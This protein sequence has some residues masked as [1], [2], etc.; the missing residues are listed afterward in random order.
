MKRFLFALLIAASPFWARAGAP[1]PVDWSPGLE[2]VVVTPHKPGPLMW[3]VSKG[4]ASVYLIGLVDPVPKDLAWDSSAVADALKGARFLLLNAQASVGLVE[5]L[6]FMTWHSDSVYLPDDTPMESTL[7][8]ALRARFVFVRDKIHRDAARYSDLRAPLAALRLEGDFFEASGLAREEPAKT[9]ERLARKA[10]VRARPLA[11]YEALPMLR[12]LP[13]MSQAANQACVS[14]AL[15]DIDAIKLHAAAAAQAWAKGDL[16]GIKANFS[17]ERFA[18]C[19]QAVPGLRALFERA[20]NDSIAAIDGAL[21]QPGKTVMLIS[22]GPLLRKGGVL[23]R[24]D[25]EGL[26]VDTL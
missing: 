26:T 4:D 3:R 2:V 20:V 17:E 19:I 14:A 11:D 16:D 7:P 21:A 10:G 8:D 25:A 22:I 15:D 5:G 18:S 1:P 13:T 23:D 6:W 24:I 9:I 12:A